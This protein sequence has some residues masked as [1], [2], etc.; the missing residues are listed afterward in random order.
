[1]AYTKTNWVNDVTP[2]NAT[3][4]NNIENGIFDNSINDKK[5]EEASGYIK[6]ENG[7]LLQWKTI[8][9]K[10][11]GTAWGNVY[12]SDHVMGDW[13]VPF[14]ALFTM[15]SDVERLQ[16]WNAHSN[17]TSTSAGTI[18]AFRPNAGTD[19]NTKITITALGLWK[20]INQNA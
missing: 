12:Y 4:M 11:G 13:E 16:Y 1:M 5:L 6:Y 10:T 17:Q 19:E 20:E 18:R 14:T 8:K 9:A 2:A 3:N 15:W 7:F